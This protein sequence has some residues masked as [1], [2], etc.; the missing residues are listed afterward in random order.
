MSEIL[1]ENI[2]NRNIKPTDSKKMNQI[3]AKLQEAERQIRRSRNILYGIALFVVLSGLVAAYIGFGYGSLWD[4]MLLPLSVAVILASCAFFA[5]RHAIVAF[6]T[7][8]IVYVLFE[9]F[10]AAPLPQTLIR[11]IVWKLGIAIFICV[12]LYYSISAYIL[13][14]ELIDATL[15]AHAQIKDDV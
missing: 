10:S 3:A 14:K 9:L 7:A 11:G 1:D 2:R 8:L 12:G 4:K 13:K 5:I 6:A 15:E